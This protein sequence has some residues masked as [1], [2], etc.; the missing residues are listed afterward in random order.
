MEQT[1]RA[2]FASSNV[3]LIA[4]ATDLA[5]AQYQP[6]LPLPCRLKAAILL[7]PEKDVA[8]GLSQI[9]QRLNPIRKSTPRLP[10]PSPA[11]E[12]GYFDASE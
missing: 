9:R 6:P 12:P 10:S 8:G 11:K 2:H 5:D 3:F 4:F 1:M 7:R